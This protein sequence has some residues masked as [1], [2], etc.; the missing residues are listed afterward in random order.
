MWVFRLFIYHKLVCVNRT[1]Q[2][3]DVLK[4][5]K[6]KIYLCSKF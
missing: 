4:K 2:K 6:V 3:P 1:K 5:E